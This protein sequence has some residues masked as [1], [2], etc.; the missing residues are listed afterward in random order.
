MQVDM[1]IF[2]QAGMYAG[3]QANTQAGRYAAL[4]YANFIRDLSQFGFKR[5]STT[6]KSIHKFSML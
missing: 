6:A 1:Q 3:R 4:T 2:R 5:E